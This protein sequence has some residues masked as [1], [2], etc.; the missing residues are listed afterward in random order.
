MGR[1]VPWSVLRS[2]ALA[3]ATLLP[4]G[5][6]LAGCQE[7]LQGDALIAAKADLTMRQLIA[8][9]NAQNRDVLARLVV[10]TST[11]GGPPRPLSADELQRVVH[12]DPP[13]EYVGAGQPGTLLMRDGR[14]RRRAVRMVVLDQQVKVLAVRS[15]LARYT[16]QEEG[17]AEG[18]KPGGLDVEI[19]T[20]LEPAPEL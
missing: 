19:V 13:F 12:P 6:L 14:G 5:C 20:L 9:L 1:C 3:A 10:V 16:A 8:G 2:V 18:P 11:T 15:T 4:A 7:P 17:R